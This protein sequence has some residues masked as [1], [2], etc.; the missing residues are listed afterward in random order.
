M[1]PLLP[2]LLLPFLAL[3]PACSTE[4]DAS[5]T[6]TATARRGAGSPV[7]VPVF[8]RPPAASAVAGGLSVLMGTGTYCWSEAGRNGVCVDAAGPVTGLQELKVGPG[9]RIDVM[10]GFPV[11]DILQAVV[12]ATA[13]GDK[14]GKPAG[15]DELVWNFPAAGG[16]QLR[17][18]RDGSGV[19]FTAPAQPGRYVASVFLRL[20]AGDVAYG[21]V[22]DVK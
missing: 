20:D 1:R 3:L 9:A 21:V 17:T 22:I 6:A 4:T 12:S 14:Q 13:V 19:S 16:S 5:V 11:A 8:A 7:A 15:I 18:A 10:A 2:L